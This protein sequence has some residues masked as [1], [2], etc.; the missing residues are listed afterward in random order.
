M[1]RLKE[2]NSAFDTNR[3]LFH[4]GK[5]NVSLLVIFTWLVD[6]KKMTQVHRAQPIIM[7]CWSSGWKKLNPHRYQEKKNPSCQWESIPG[8]IRHL[9]Q[10]ITDNEYNDVFLERSNPIY[11]NV[12]GQPSQHP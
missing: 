3:I 2:N 12:T 5:I 9:H 10:S 4:P 1:V 8:S 11:I 7:P 6:A